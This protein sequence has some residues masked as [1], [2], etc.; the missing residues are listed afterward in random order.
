MTEFLRANPDAFSAIRLFGSKARGDGDY[1]SDTDILII[2]R[3]GDPGRF[4]DSVLIAL[5]D[6][7][8]MS[9]S[10]GWYSENR[11]A[12]IYEEGDLFAW[13]LYKESRKL[14]YTDADF[15]DSLVPSY[16]RNAVRDV[17]TFL[18]IIRGVHGSLEVAPGNAAYEAGV[19]FMASRNIAM[20]V[21]WYL[22]DG[23]LF[24]RKS[25]F[26]LQERLGI[27]FPISEREHEENMRAR[28]LGHRGVPVSR[29][30]ASLVADMAERLLVWG[31][32]V[33]QFAKEADDAHHCRP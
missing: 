8:G 25:P 11:I 20:S 9:P 14:G 29:R 15:L 7:F 19:L 4:R 16:Y 12:S 27:P 10:V 21:S 23:L 5:R 2:K 28:V 18:D 13:H 26:Q 30:A 32:T 24:G 22:P 31:T 3:S 17:Q 6:S 33:L 1:L